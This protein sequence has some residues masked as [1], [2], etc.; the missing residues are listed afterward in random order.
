LPQIVSDWN[1]YRDSVR[2]GV[3]GFLIPT[4][5]PPASAGDD[6]IFR[7]AVGI[8]NFDQYLASTS[9]SIA[10]DTPN[11]IKSLEQLV[12]NPELRNRMSQAALA[13]ARANFNWP[14]II[15]CYQELW[16]DLSQRRMTALQVVEPRAHP[17]RDDPFSV[18]S[19][20]ATCTLDA[21]CILELGPNGWPSV[22]RALTAMPMNRVAAHLMCSE[23][24][25]G[26]IIKIVSDEFPLLVGDLLDRMPGHRR[27]T[28]HRTLGWL[29]KLGAL[30][31]V[32]LS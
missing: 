11:Y 28:A 22:L 18:F 26:E 15:R 9:Q 4:I 16:N 31:V 12:V 17:L 10:I 20:Y 23:Q 7:H 29:T 3:D 6:L 25:I 5:M 8:D 19:Q 1:G 32:G 24:E 13:R 30:N 21:N 2:H 27:A 14:V